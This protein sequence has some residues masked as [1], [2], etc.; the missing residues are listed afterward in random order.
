[1]PRCT[2]KNTNGNVCNQKSDKLE[3]VLLYDP[4]QRINQV[5][6]GCQLHMNMII[7]DLMVEQMQHE[8]HMRAMIKQ[9]EKL[10]DELRKG[11]SV[12]EERQK[13]RDAKAEGLPE[14]KGFKKIEEL[15]QE[16]KE[17]WQS[18]KNIKSI[19]QKKRNKHKSLF[20]KE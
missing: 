15:K 6:Y 20:G 9:I 16:I 18:V 12:A 4:H 19:L 17:K 5:R 11:M 3:Y 10:N 7:E 8:R 13:I 1:M 14:P 2:F